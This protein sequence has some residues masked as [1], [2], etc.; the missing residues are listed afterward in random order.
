MNSE[1]RRSNETHETY[2]DIFN[3]YL[4]LGHMTQMSSSVPNDKAYFIPHHSVKLSRI[5]FNASFIDDS[6]TS[7]NSHLLAGPVSTPAEI[8]FSR[9]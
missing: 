6:L 1:Y 7:L 3:E 9:Y 5:V 4:K 2:C 8:N